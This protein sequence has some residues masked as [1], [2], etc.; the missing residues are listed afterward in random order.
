MKKFLWL[1]IA[2]FSLASFGCSDNESD[3]E[4]KLIGTWYRKYSSV[5]STSGMTLNPDNTGVTFYKDSRWYFTW[6]YNGSDLTITHANDPEL[7][8]SGTAV[9]L[10]NGN[11]FYDG[12]VYTKN[13]DDCD[14][15]DVWSGGGS[16]SGYAPSSLSRKTLNL[17]KS[18]GSYWMGIYHLEGGQCSVDLYNG[19]MLATS[20]PPKYS[21][22]PSGS[23]ASYNLTFTTQTYV[24][25]YGSNTYAQFKEKIVLKFSSSIAGTYSGT[26]TNGY[27]TSKNISGNF[28][29]Q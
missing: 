28:K 24:P 26:Q 27:G 25:Y 2:I 1:L 13:A 8:H 12:T 17:Y 29:I 22:S 11:L 18:D 7:D 5:G 6:N 23:S 19:A 3:L 20:Y 10:D 9:I 15:D 4:N 21:Y 14:S 16:S